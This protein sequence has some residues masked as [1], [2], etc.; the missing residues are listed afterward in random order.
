M[1]FKTP[2]IFHLAGTRLHLM[3]TKGYLKHL[4]APEWPVDPNISDAEMLIEICG[5]S[6]YKSFG[7]EL[8]PN[9]TKVREGN[10]A[11]LGN[12]I[13]TEHGSV[14]EHAYD[15]FAFCDVSR[16]FTH[17]LV[18]H[19]LA[20]YS[21]ESMRFIRPTALST[22]FPQVY[23]DHLSKGKAAQVRDLFETVFEY[24]E[25]IQQNLV[26]ICGMDDPNLNFNLKKLFQSA[27]RRLI[28]DGVLTGIITTFNHRTGRFVIAQRTS[29]HA[30]EEIRY[31][32]YQ[33]FKQLAT[34]Y[35]ALYQDAIVGE[36]VTIYDK[37]IAE[38]KFAHHKI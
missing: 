38:V 24:I 31:V 30:E 3:P 15:T 2:S 33:V 36:E 9:I 37:Q 34:K 28:P 18:R 23:T 4:G 29:V 11:Y 14:I 32:Y 25:E 17:E 5:R 10:T 16:V 26:D 22:I 6:C 20:N 7:T 1:Q 21:Q 27:N 19:R 12:I 13:K 8:N 35:P